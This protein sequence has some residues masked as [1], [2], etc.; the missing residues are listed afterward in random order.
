VDSEHPSAR[1]A[2]DHPPLSDVVTKGN[3]DDRLDT[4]NTRYDDH[5]IL[6]TERWTAH[7]DVHEVVA[8]SL[9]EYKRD[10][11]EWRQTLADLRSTF[12]PK[13]EYQAEHRALE[14][15]LHGET[16][17]LSSILHGEIEKLASI[18]NALDIRID[19]NTSDIK[20]ARVES[21]GRRSVFTDTRSVLTVLGIVLGAV[22]TG[23]LIID[24]LRP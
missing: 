14:A 13:A 11:N 7:R 9:R 20:D 21:L 22:A 2:T 16:D 3:L 5:I 19:S 1:R 12:I 24:R 8:E 17:S 18:V 15:K 6:A 23:L 4:V 10:A